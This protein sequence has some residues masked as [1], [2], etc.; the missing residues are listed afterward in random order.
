MPYDDERARQEKLHDLKPRNMS[1]YQYGLLKYVR[2]NHVTLE[3]LRVAHG[4]TLGSVAY[5]GWIA[6]TSSNDDSPIVLTKT[7]RAELEAYEAA[8]LPIRSTEGEL[9]ERCLRLLMHSR[10]NKVVEL[11]K[12]A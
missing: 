4:T 1:R 11:A 5:W 9:T 3:Q 6:R 8:D 12:P 7:G 2:N 10:R